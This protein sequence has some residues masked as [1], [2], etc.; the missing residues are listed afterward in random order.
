MKKRT[1]EFIGIQSG[2]VGTARST[3]TK[4]DT[5]I[6]GHFQEVILRVS[7][8]EETG[9]HVGGLFQEEKEVRACVFSCMK[10]KKGIRREYREEEGE[11]RRVGKGE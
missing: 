9:K 1:S 2:G 6:I 4:V 3:L 11:G 10:K 7:S 5:S 8:T